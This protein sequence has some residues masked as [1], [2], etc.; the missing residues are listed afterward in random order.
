[1]LQS[2]R[3]PETPGA[4]T[5]IV[6]PH[7][8]SSP[9]TGVRSCRRSKRRAPHCNPKGSAAPWIRSS[10]SIALPTLRSARWSMGRGA[11]PGSASLRG[12]VVSAAGYWP[13]FSCPSP[14]RPRLRH[15]RAP[16]D[17]PTLARGGGEN[18]SGSRPS[19]REARGPAAK[20]RLARSAF[21]RSV[22]VRLSTVSRCRGAPAR[23]QEPCRIA[24]GR[25]PP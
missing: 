14:Q 16:S 15:G 6:R 8:P 13:A 21:P 1:V 24:Q 3:I 5:C 12:F 10:R 7:L 23:G 11:S 19:A 20:T 2:W 25:P 18:R 17:A 22:T 4:T 9:D